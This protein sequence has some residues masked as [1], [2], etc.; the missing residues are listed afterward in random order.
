MNIEKLPQYEL[1][2]Q[3]RLEDIRSD[4]YLLRH[5]KSGAR[6]LVLENEDENKVF[7]IAF[8]TPP[9]DSTGVAHILEHSVLCGS[10]L[11]PA[12]DPFVELVKGSLN[13][14][15]NAMTYPDK[16]MYPVASCNDKDFCNLM[17]VYLDAVFY[18][19]IYKK[20]EIFRQ[21]GWSYQLGSPEDELIYNGVVYNEMK[22]AFSSPEDVLER[23]IMNS[24]F[25]D[26]AYGVESGG[27]PKC[28][29]D[30]TYEEFLDFHR[31][32][33]HPSNS[34][35]YLYGNMDVQERLAWLDREYLDNFEYKQV[36]SAIRRQEP[37]QAPIEVFRKYPVTESDELEDSTYLSYNTVVGTSLDVELSNAFAV[38][39]YALLSAPGAVLKQALLDAGIG[40]DIMSSY[41]SGIYQPVFSIIAKN[42]NRRDLAR[43]QE[44]IRTTLAQV[45][46]EGIDRN[47]LL[48]GINAMEF[49]AR[50]ADYGSYPKGLMYGLDLF[51]SWLYDENMP[52]DYLKFD[53]YETLRRRTQEDYYEELIR[54]YLLENPHTSCVIVE[55]E[56]GLTARTGEAVRKK[57]EAYRASL[58]DEQVQELIEKTAK[59]RQFQETP[60]T[61]GELE[62]IPM[63][64]REDIGRRAAS[65]YNTEYHWNGTTVL[66]HN[67]FTNGIAYLDLLFDISRIAREDIPYLGVLKAVLGMVD[68]EHYTY[69][70]LNSEILINTGGISAGLNVYPVLPEGEELRAFVGLR[71]RVLYDKLPFAFEMAEEILLHSSLEQ[72]KRLYE[73]LARLKSRLSMQLPSA[74]HATAAG[75]A[76]SYFSQSAAF[77][78]AVG[79]ITFYRLVDD[80]E[81]HFEERKQ[82]LRSKLLQMMRQLFHRE[83]LFVSLTCEEEGLAR[84]R[85]PFE[86]FL[87]KLP[88]AQDAVQDNRL[89]TEKKN[90]GFMTPGQVQYVARTGN[91]REAGFSYT[92]V[93]RIV[94]V[95]M[96]YDY[97]WTNIRVKGGAY[98][99]MSSFGPTGDAYF[100]SYRDPNLRATDEVYEGIPA[101]LAAFHASEREMTKYI[102]GTVSEL[103][104]PLP[105]A[106][107]GYRSLGAYFSKVTQEDLQRERDEILGATPQQI[108]ELADL[109]RAVLA[110][111]A[112]CVIGNEDRIKQ[113]QD[114][115]T[116]IQML[117]E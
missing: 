101:Y 65:L 91:F 59:L 24:L 70:N 47:V 113:D 32:Y 55:P 99:C 4:G 26:T 111:Q 69:Q 6:I 7:N 80:L 77:N 39:E 61:L 75:R 13:T 56:R 14:F 30:L 54:T 44:V 88:A 22:G 74:G 85:G 52:F 21:E 76:L 114:L 106:S 63:L 68:T 104:T 11:F 36:D 82:E 110:C 89:R 78:D 8:R 20:E 5:K 51:D 9:A 17:H 98:G 33:Y 84:M 35:I 45:A 29:P 115:F 16:T 94:K 19:N 64:S 67:I 100:V 48:A 112:I 83:G 108:R 97:L 90:E 87:E 37:F 15:L 57:L 72:D 43:F 50:E 62:K 2:K 58:T 66:H 71:A 12:K 40:N 3:E 23:E 53:V 10:R 31:R 93:L 42:A 107:R 1:L 116:S 73:I 18:P 103:D 109:V 41:D 46:R 60:S 96:S 105:P 27:D 34:Y 25:P 92:G 28:I 81:K 49:K 79:G 102:I 95:L 117:A 38:L 86:A